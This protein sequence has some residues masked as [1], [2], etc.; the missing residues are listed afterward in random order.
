MGMDGIGA[1]GVMVTCGEG[2]R[3]L[4]ASARTLK[5]AS[6]GYTGLEEGTS[7]NLKEGGVSEGADGE[8]SGSPKSAFIRFLAMVYYIT[9]LRL[10]QPT[11]YL[12]HS[13][14]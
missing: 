7:C 14:H 12:L 5:L 9:Y 2:I 13:P 10:N 8:A 11:H 6:I 3:D 4:C 1:S